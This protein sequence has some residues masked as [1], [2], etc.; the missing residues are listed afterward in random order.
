[1]GIP[2]VIIFLPI[3]WFLLAFVTS[4]IPL[5]K[6]VFE[7][8][9]AI[10]MAISLFLIPVNRKKQ[11]FLLDWRTTRH[12][13]PWGIV[14]LF[15]GG[16]ALAAGFGE[17]G[18][19]KW[20]GSHLQLLGGLPVLI[21]ILIVCL[22][23]TFLTEVTS[24]TATATMILPILA[25]TAQALDKHPFILMMPAAISASC[26]F[27]LP[28]ATPPN[29]IVFG[30]GWVNITKMA[31]TGLVLNLIGVAIISLLVYF[32]APVILGIDVSSFPDWAKP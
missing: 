2:V 8:T 18:L 24:N 28:V 13:V 29:A 11:E 26:A 16:F 17:T 25:V 31:R 30:S 14:L 1:M 4:K 9:V 7:K 20:I 6:F 23:M 21:I 32:L 5:R 22:M 12:T 3:T 15:G 19:D 10:C 27:M